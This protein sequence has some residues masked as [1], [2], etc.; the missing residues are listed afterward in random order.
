[1]VGVGKRQERLGK[2][3]EREEGVLWRSCIDVGRCSGRNS[4]QDS[5]DG[6]GVVIRQQNELG[7]QV[8]ELWLCKL[9]DTN[10]RIRKDGVISATL[11]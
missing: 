3:F 2:L 10:V 6:L 4:L 5:Q 7:A 1:M 9:A 11:V 8:L